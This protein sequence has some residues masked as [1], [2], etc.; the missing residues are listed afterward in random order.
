MIVAANTPNVMVRATKPR[1]IRAD[2]VLMTC[3]TST[4]ARGSRA[5]QTR[6]F[7][8]RDVYTTPRG[9]P[10]DPSSFLRLCGPA[11]AGSGRQ[12]VGWKAADRDPRSRGLRQR[13]RHRPGHHEGGQG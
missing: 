6:V 7:G 1:R 11:R 13:E 8:G 2:S 3:V 10:D 9:T 5:S 4:V 12:G